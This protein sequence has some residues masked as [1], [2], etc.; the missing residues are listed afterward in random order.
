MIE[1]L[2]AYEILQFNE[3]NKNKL[4]INQLWVSLCA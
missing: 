3:K 2:S 4:V 1:L